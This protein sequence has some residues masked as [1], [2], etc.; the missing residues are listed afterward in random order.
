MD[1][2][3]KMR[4]I[5]IGNQ[6]YSFFWLKWPFDFFLWSDSAGWDGRIYKH[7]STEVYEHVLTICEKRAKSA[8]V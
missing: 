8:L 1:L 6:E 3:Q 7:L 2:N 4:N 5:Q